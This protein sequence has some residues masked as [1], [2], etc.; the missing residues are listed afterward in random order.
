[1]SLA[2]N[3]KLKFDEDFR[4]RIHNK[5]IKIL[6]FLSRSTFDKENKYFLIS[7]LIEIKSNS[8][9]KIYLVPFSFSLSSATQYRV[10][11]LI[12]RSK[13]LT[14]IENKSKG[15]IVEILSN[16][17]LTRLKHTNLIKN[18]KHGDHENDIIYLMENSIWGIE[19][20]YRSN[21]VITYVLIS[22]SALSMSYNSERP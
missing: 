5:I 17:I 1:M 18:F 8:N 13:R 22:F 19:I 15:K 6:N 3:L 14:Q 11:W 12:N 16:E 21:K 10:D 4:F 2:Q 20:T 9:S 7:P